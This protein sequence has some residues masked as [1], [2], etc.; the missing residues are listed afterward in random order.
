MPPGSA[1]CA[2]CGHALVEP[3]VTSTGGER[4]H[5]ACADAQ[6]AA[7]W[8]HRR[9][10]A[11]GHL[12]SIALVLLALTMWAGPSPTLLVVGL[13]WAALHVRLHQRYWHYIVRDLRR[14]LRRR[15]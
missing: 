2:L 9:R 7:A 5:L 10:L 12:A 14:A 15:A 8:R 13:A 6:A 1:R 4:C 3:S 11:Q